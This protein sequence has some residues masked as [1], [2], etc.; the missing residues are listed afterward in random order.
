MFDR[1]LQNVFECL[2]ESLLSLARCLNNVDL[3]KDDRRGEYIV[4][5]TDFMNYFPGT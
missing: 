1:K 3:K 4:E 2:L 5:S